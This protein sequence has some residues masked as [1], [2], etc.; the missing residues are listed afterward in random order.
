MG[1]KASE[2][3]LERLI[4]DPVFRRQ[5]QVG[6]Y[7]LIPHRHGLSVLHQDFFAAHPDFA[8]QFPG[9]IAQFAEFAGNMPEDALEELMIAHADGFREEGRGMPGQF[10]DQE[11]RNADNAGE[12][13]PQE[14][15]DN[16]LQA[17]QQGAVPAGFNV[18]E[19]RN[20]DGDTDDED[21]EDEDE[22]RADVAVRVQTILETFSV[23]TTQTS[24]CLYAFC[25]MCSTGSGVHQRNRLQTRRIITI[26]SMTTWTSS[27]IA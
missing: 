26:R 27:R 3:M 23:L 17:W 12:N 16:R 10:D 14:H 11:L 22:N 1:R 2:R 15:L 6:S 21:D 5:L 19:D 18:P 13:R 9:G 4:P 7:G 25:G 24:Q 20:D 8:Q